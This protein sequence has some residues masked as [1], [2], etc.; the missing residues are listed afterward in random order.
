MDITSKKSR[1][2]KEKIPYEKLASVPVSIFRDR[3]L[4]VLEALVLYLKNTGLT[5]KEI[6]LHLNRDQRTI[7]TVYNRAKKK[8]N[9]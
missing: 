7:W 5:F 4:S 1:L 3:T 6:S 9:G 8:K 2:K